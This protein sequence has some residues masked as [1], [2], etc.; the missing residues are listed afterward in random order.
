MSLKLAKRSK[1]SALH[2]LYFYFLPLHCPNLFIN[3]WKSGG[4]LTFAVQSEIL[5]HVL[6]K[7]LTW[8]SMVRPFLMLKMLLVYMIS[9][10]WCGIKRTG[11]CWTGSACV[12]VFQ[13]F[14]VFMSF[15]LRAMFRQIQ[16]AL[17]LLFPQKSWRTRLSSVNHW[18]RTK[19]FP[20]K[21]R[22]L[23]VEH[24]QVKATPL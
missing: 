23:T 6:L 21:H 16:R 9:S 14:I 22:R 4:G 24:R 15:P 11:G 12:C 17:I 7:I 1:G 20:V 2:V 19:G 13:M 8:L 3:P 10:C 5:V 18:C